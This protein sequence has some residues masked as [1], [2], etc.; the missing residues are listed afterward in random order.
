MSI[1]CGFD[2][3]KEQPYV[4]I[5]IEVPM[6]DISRECPPLIGEVMQWLQ[7]NGLSPS[8]SPFFR[9]LNFGEYETIDV[10]WPVATLPSKLSGRIH[11]AVL[12]AGR[13]VTALYTGPYHGIPGET[14][15][16]LEACERDDVPLDVSPPP[17]R[18]GG[19]VE[20]YITDPREVSDPQQW[21]T[22]IAILLKD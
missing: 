6:T 22:E 1:Q 17:K 18:W 3:R 10:G 19:Y 8:G 4:A 21:Q 9:Y 15:R 12:P 20:W 14:Q 5:R 13:Y 16:F 11:A 7:A 2:Q